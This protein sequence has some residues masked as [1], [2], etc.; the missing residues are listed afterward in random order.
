MEKFHS[1]KSFGNK[2]IRKISEYS[3]TKC[4]FLEKMCKV[5]NKLGIIDRPV[6][7]LKGWINKYRDIVDDRG[8]LQRMIN[9]VITAYNDQPNT[10][11]NNKTP[12]EAFEVVTKQNSKKIAE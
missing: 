12:N 5:P 6:W 7:T 2:N 10:G 4:M 3:D 1:E 9:S 8:T 11:I